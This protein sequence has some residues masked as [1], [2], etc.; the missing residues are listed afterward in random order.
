VSQPFSTEDVLRAEAAAIHGSDAAHPLSEKTG[1]A[2]YQALN[3][4][5]SA[6]LCLSG[7]GIRS[8]AFA[9][10]VLQAL[11]MHPRSAKGTACGQAKHSLLTKFHYLST[12]S[13]GGY[14]GSWLAT[15]R[16]REDFAPLW[17]RLTGRPD[18]P[19]IEPHTVGWLRS[20]TNYLTPKLGVMSADAWTDVALFVRN[21]IL[22]WLIIIPF[23][24]AVILLLKIAAIGSDWATRVDDWRVQ[25]P[26]AVLGVVCLVVELAFITRH[27]PSRRDDEAGATGI[28]QRTYLL[29]GLLW[30]IASAVFLAQFLSSDFVGMNFLATCPAACPCAENVNMCLST[31]G[32]LVPSWAMASVVGL[33]ALG[34]GGLYALSWLVGNPAKMDLRD[35]VFWTAAGCVYGA[36]VAFG[37]Y[38]YLQ[39]PEEGITLFSKIKLSSVVLQIVFG[40]PWILLSRAVAEMIFVGLSSYEAKAEAD[41]EWLGRTG[42]WIMAAALGWFVL[43]FLAFFGAVFGWDDV[44]SAAST[45]IAPLGGISGLVAALLGSSGFTRAQ[46][47][48]KGAKSLSVNVILSIAAPIFAAALIICLSIGLDILLLSEAL[49]PDRFSDWS[50]NPDDRFATLGLLAIGFICLSGIAVLASCFININRF[51]LHALYRNRLVRA[52]LGA[53]RDR[54][55]D[56]LTGLD[57][58]DNPGMENLWPPK[59][60]SETEGNGGWAPFLVVNTTLNIVSAKRLA[61][62]ERK[63]A[64]FVMTPLH[65]GYGSK[66]LAGKDAPVGAFRASADYG[67]GI[68]LGTAMAISG[69]AASPNMGYH[70][71]PGVTFL[72]TLFNVRLGWWLGNPAEEGRGTFMRE[73]PLFAVAPLAQETFGLTTDDK[74]YIYLSDG[75]HF[76]NLGLYEMVRR[77]CRTIIVCDAGC[78]PD[79]KFEDLGNAVRK[80]AI[81]LGVGIR[82]SKLDTLKARPETGDVGPNQDYHAMGE[83]D[84]RAADGSTAE[85]GIILYI[86]AGYH[87]VESA[88]VRAYAMANPEFPH[89]ATLNQWF[90]ESQFESYRVLGFEIADG[91]LNEAVK[92]SDYARDP[93]LKTIFEVLKKKTRPSSGSFADVSWTP[94]TAASSSPTRPRLP[95]ARSPG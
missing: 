18:G 77:R 84:Y 14:I 81:D 48:A 4:L 29:H 22:N 9:L 67:A 76:E 79:F 68:T 63:A 23:A 17:A 71:S 59:R 94:A 1:A 91:I 27:R 6:A 11:A 7:G 44:W 46:G 55:P 69:A 56:A 12:V 80:I 86:K 60:H 5:E 40:V 70:S 28:D 52:F 36:A 73:G 16:T 89:Q 33:G 10:G 78:D 88:G 50:D 72:M 35:F 95:R 45:W 13:G 58:E 8:A 21:L 31:D 37:F 25:I 2:L 85:N 64:S 87:G 47:P 30:S 53:S 20:Y 92:D 41:R 65:C 66:C 49:V 32:D 24:C 43:M 26:F 74:K 90:T 51:S 15:W 19:D 54:K 82:F 34:G 38:L 42:G 83:I 75:G 57:D 39:I 3:R 93:S 61:W 62:Q